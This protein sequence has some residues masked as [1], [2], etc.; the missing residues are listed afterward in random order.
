MTLTAGMD[1]N[2]QIPNP[3]PV[4]GKLNVTTTPLGAKIYIDGKWWEVRLNT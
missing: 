1:K 4:Y 3:E 2:I